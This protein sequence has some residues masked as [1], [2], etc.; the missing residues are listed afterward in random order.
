MS[1]VRVRL[2]HQITIPARIAEAAHIKPDD[3]LEVA[4][5]NGVVTL[6][7]VN[8]KARKGSAMAYAGIARGLWGQTTAEIEADLKGG[9]DS[10]ER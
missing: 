2:K 4:Y 1:Q 9:H 7:P 10:W 8:R 6:V 5:A 3:M